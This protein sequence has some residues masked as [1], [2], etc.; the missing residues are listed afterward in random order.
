MVRR[1][2]TLTLETT[3]LTA[4]G[5]LCVGTAGERCDLLALVSCR[6]PD[7]GSLALTLSGTFEWGRGGDVALYDG[8]GR[9]DLGFT[10]PGFPDVTAFACTDCRMATANVSQQLVPDFMGPIRTVWTAWA[11]TDTGTERCIVLSTPP[12]AGC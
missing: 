9:P 2:A 1:N 3:T 6:G 4:D 8:D 11:C 7:C 10:A 5:Q 12:L